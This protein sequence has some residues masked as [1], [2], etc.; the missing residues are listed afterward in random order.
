MCNENVYRKC[1]MHK[2]YNENVCK[3]EQYHIDWPS[4]REFIL[5]V[6][7]LQI[8]NWDQCDQIWRNFAFLPRFV[9]PLNL[10]ETFI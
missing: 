6:Q 1:I 3:N 7:K 5:I 8:S 2:M 9:K 10:F 4:H